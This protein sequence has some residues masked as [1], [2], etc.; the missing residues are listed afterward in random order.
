MRS[1][2]DARR[3]RNLFV[4]VAGVDERVLALGLY[5]RSVHEDQVD[6]RVLPL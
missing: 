5:L 2:G 4:V 1:L 6:E 3:G